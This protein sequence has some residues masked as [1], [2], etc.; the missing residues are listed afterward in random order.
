[1]SQV[2]ES[3]LSLQTPFNMVVMVVLIG[4]TAG[5]ITGIAKEVRKYMCHREEVELKRDL[6]ARGMSATEID[7]VVRSQSPSV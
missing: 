6:L 2:L 7:Q 5:V 3:I 1:M 4:C